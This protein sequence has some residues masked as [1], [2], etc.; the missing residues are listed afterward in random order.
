MTKEGFDVHQHITDKIVSAIERGAG[1]FRLPWH[2]AAGATMRPVNIASKK[3]YRGV[4][5]VALWAHSEER[6]I[7]L[8]VDGAN[9]CMTASALGIDIDYRRLLRDFQG[10]G[11]LIRAT[12]YA[13]EDNEYS[14]VQP[15]VDWLTL[16]GYD[17]VIKPAK[18][19]V[20]SLGRQKLKRNVNV[21]LAAD[22]IRMSEHVDH[23]VVFS[24]DGDLRPLV[25]L[26]QRKGAQVT[27]VSTAA[28]TPQMVAHDLRRQAD[29]FIDLINFVDKRQPK[30]SNASV[31]PSSPG[32]P[33][34]PERSVP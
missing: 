15:L 19:F 34:E 18:K 2:R 6:G 33:T 9:L 30:C 29:E 26:L 13:A 24:G 31:L 28:T 3:A 20:D 11:R 10:K 23:L 5:I 7:A 32:K 14:S 12:Y 16:N 27:I 22:A 25:N 8:F 17:V 1:E 4:N 21:E